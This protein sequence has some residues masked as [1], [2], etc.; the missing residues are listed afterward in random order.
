MSWIQ[1]FLCVLYDQGPS[2]VTADDDAFWTDFGAPQPGPTPPPQPQQL[3]VKDEK[4]QFTLLHVENWR[5]KFSGSKA[6]ESCVIGQV[7]TCPNAL[8]MRTRFQLK[9][10]SNCPQGLEHSL[11]SSSVRKGVENGGGKGIFEG[12]ASVD[13]VLLRYKLWPGS[14]LEPVV[15]RLSAGR[16]GKECNGVMV[17]LVEF[18]ASTNLTGSATGKF[19]SNDH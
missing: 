5:A 3:L 19:F 6:I 14:F 16:L 17:L 18:A 13:C 10:P 2:P 1:A 9:Q 8:P 7:S 4:P 15:F 12:N 11:R